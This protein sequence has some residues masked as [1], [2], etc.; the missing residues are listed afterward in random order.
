M[1]VRYL[2]AALVVSL[3]AL[4]AY[5]SA[6]TLGVG[7]PAPSLTVGKWVKG[8]P[9]KGFEKGKLYVVEFW[10]TWCGPCRESIPHLTEMAKANPEVT[11]VG[12][13]VWE[14][15][16]SKVEPFVAQMGDKMNYHVAM[17]DKSSVDKGAMA[18]NWMEAADQ[19]GI[20]TAFIVDKE[21][22]IA[23]IGHPMEMAPVL[24]K[25]VAGNYD[26][27]EAK[28]EAAKR[29]Q[30]QG[31]QA[32]LQD[33]LGPLMQNQ[34]FDGAAKAIDDMIAA[35]P[36]SKGLL[37]QV[38]FSV[39]ISG[40]KYD[41]AY[42]VADEV[43][44]SNKDDAQQLN[45]LAWFMVDNKALKTRDLDRALKIATRAVEVSE[46]KDAAILDTLARIHFDKGEVS[47]AIAVETEAVAAADDSLKADLQKTLDQYKAAEKK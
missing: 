10:A 3:S 21:G 45:A 23:W 24:K 36:E 34:D 8:E 43:A 27:N 26:M 15:D 37:D 38:K 4:G 35:H 25:V 9:V 31:L 6:A 14:R 1:R 12:T 28:K 5:A 16:D 18:T 47:K 41:A 29:E 2:A 7:D 13:S 39:L 20:P 19:N 32:E 30:A 33:K 42:K 11:F 40:G 17:D 44:E 22:N 46:H